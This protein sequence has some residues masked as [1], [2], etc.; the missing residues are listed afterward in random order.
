M[1]WVIA[2]LAVTLALAASHADA[3]VYTLVNGATATFTSPA[4]C[5]AGV[6]QIVSIQTG[7][8][9]APAANVAVSVVASTS[10]T[11]T[12]LGSNDR[13]NWTPAVSG[14][15]SVATGTPANGVGSPIGSAEFVATWQYWS[16]VVTAVSGS[17]TVLISG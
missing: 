4:N 14:G 13:V 15:A 6:C 12:I 1:K 7:T 3:A 17:C 5:T 10:C 2:A 16:A 11:A 9:G 8:S